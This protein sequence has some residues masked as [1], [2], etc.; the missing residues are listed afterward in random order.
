[1]T[2]ACWADPL[3][4]TER[5]ALREKLARAS[6]RSWDAAGP[7]LFPTGDSAALVLISAEM[8]DLHLDVTERAAVP[9]TIKEHS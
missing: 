7:G 3:S 6:K 4:R 9:G 2:A 1:M 5:R 8:S